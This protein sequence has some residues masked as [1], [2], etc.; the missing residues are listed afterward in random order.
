[1]TDPFPELPRRVLF[2]DVTK[3]VTKIPAPVTKIGGVTK[4]SDAPNAVTAR[5]LR[6]ADRG[7]DLTRS[8]NAAD[9]FGKLKIR[10]RGRP[11]KGAKPM[12]AAERKRQS[13]AAKKD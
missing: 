11:A 10:G 8:K 1:M 7:E 13:R 5:A 9:L 12:T 6:K 4:I 2:V 3:P